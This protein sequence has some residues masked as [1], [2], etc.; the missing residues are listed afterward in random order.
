L[1]IAACLGGLTGAVLLLVLPGSV[2]RTV[3]PALIVIA[4]VLIAVQPRL[5]E[6]LAA[7]EGDRPAH[8]GTP[9]L[10]TVYATGIYGGYFGAAQGVILMSLLAIFIPEDLQRL[11]AI[12]NVL[13]MLV[14]GVAAVL[15]IAVT[16]VAWGAA[17]LLA[18]GSIGGGQLGATVGR[19]L[20]APALRGAIIVVGLVAA[21]ALIATS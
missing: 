3:V 5:S 8:G 21:V 15:F 11:N 6:K 12:K 4:C 9:L 14:N 2:F 18:V 17:A 20:P 1:G 19:K 13:A 10:A 16:H 7:R